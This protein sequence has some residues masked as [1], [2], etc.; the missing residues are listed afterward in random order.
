MLIAEILGEY[1]FPFLME[2][3]RLSSPTAFIAAVVFP[4]YFALLMCCYGICKFSLHNTNVFLK[5][6]GE[7]SGF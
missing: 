3:D 4:P 6:L 7:D 5:C 1:Q 2:A